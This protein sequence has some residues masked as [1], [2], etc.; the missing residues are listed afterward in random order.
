MAEA[1][2]VLI[3]SN[4]RALDGRLRGSLGGRL[5]KSLR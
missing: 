3:E 4:F 2:H 1:R 5:P